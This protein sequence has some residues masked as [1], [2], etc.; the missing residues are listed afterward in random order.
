MVKV[1]TPCTFVLRLSLCRVCLGSCLLRHLPRARGP[2]IVHCLTRDGLPEL[3][4][5]DRRCSS[6]LKSTSLWRLEVIH[7]LFS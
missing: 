1:R 5:R 4:R 3:S 7:H 2:P 6:R